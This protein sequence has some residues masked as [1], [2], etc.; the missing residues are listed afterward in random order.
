MKSVNKVA[1]LCIFACFNLTYFDLV[2][3]DT[4]VNV[5]GLFIGKAVVVINNGKPQMLSVGQTV[6]VV[7]LIASDSETATFQ[8]EGKRKTLGMGQAVSVSGSTN[9]A[10]HQ[11]VTLYANSGGHHVGEAIING[12]P[13]KYIVDTGATTVAMNSGDAKYANI[14]YTK[15]SIGRVSTANGD[16]NVYSV[17][18]NSLKLGAITLNNVDAVVIEGGSPPLVLLGNSALTRLDMKQDG[19]A[20]TLTKKY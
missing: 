8:I 12:V 1:L 15:G 10:D 5:V 2:F 13:L 4:Q 16:V 7:K 17:K 20:L 18:L 3:A 14:D 6:G 9:T 11:S 19:I